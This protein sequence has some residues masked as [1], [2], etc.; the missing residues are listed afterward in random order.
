MLLRTGQIK[1]NNLLLNKE[2][3]SAL[4]MLRSKLNKPFSVEE[5]KKKIT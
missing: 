1:V 4:L 2:T 3:D 5:K